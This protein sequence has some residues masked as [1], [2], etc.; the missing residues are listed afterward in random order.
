MKTSMVVGIG[1]YQPCIVFCIYYIGSHFLHYTNF[2]ASY[3]SECLGSIDYHILL[4]LIHYY[5]Q[6]V[7]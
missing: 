6:S 2:L 5:G 1:E 7:E 4:M 3:V